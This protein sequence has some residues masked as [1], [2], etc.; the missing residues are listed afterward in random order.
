[1]LPIIVA[2]CIFHGATSMLRFVYCPV[3]CEPGIETIRQRRKQVDSFHVNL[4]GQ[5]D[6][7]V[8]CMGRGSEGVSANGRC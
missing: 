2:D 6:R 1:M 5:N 3:L 4:W 7:K 8:E